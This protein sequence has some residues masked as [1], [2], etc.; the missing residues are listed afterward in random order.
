MIQTKAV[1]VRPSS[2]RIPFLAL[3]LSVLLCLSAWPLAAIAKPEGPARI[4]AGAQLFTVEPLIAYQDVR[5]TVS[6]PGGFEVVRTFTADQAPLVDLPGD[7]GLYKYELRFSPL[8]SRDD[9][10]LLAAARKAGTEVA[11]AGKDAERLVQRGWFSVAGGSLV[12][13]LREQDPEK[14]VL[15][16]ANGVIRNALCV[17]VDCPDSPAFGDSSVLMMENNNRIKFGDTSAAPFPNNDWEIEAN[18][19]LSGGANYLG[20]NDCGTADNDGDCAT[21]LVFAVEA[22]ARQSALFVES[23][24]DVGI[25]TSNPVVDLHIVT[26]NTP[27]LRLDQDGSSG[28]APQVWDIAGNETNFFVRDVTG[29]STL[30]FRIQP[31]APSSS[32]F[33]AADADVGLG[34]ASP[35]TI[36]DGSHASLHVLRSDG[37]ASILVEETSA[38]VDNARFLL[39]LRNRGNANFT[40]RDT[41]AN[42]Q[43][44]FSAAGSFRINRQGSGVS[45]LTLASGGNLTIAGQLF[46]AGS[47]SI[48]CDRVFTDDYDVES[49]EEHAEYMWQNRHL[50]GVGP[51]PEGA[52]M[53]VSAKTEGILNELEKAHI[54]IEQLNQGLKE[55]DARIEQLAATVARLVALVEGG[56]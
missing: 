2:L 51:T 31:G 56:E 11:D 37:D 40:L 43:W 13:D 53:N 15:T 23:D 6:G 39:E 18:S 3:L 55:R 14:V 27:A 21:D 19:N 20:F 38:T 29:G 45:E 5:V 34:T 42:T 17:G 30:P 8:L 7:D 47:C 1:D 49:I 24:G 46:T 32:V 16:N 50:E 52:P 33:I 48:G 26:G 36:V 4:D 25:G 9:R 54:Y 22:G 12:P 10:E 35:G 41:N 28:F 44:D